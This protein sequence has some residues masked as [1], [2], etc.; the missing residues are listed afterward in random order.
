[1]H[2]WFLEI[3]SSMNIGVYVCV[4]PQEGLITS[5]VKVTCNN[6]ISKFYG[7]SV[8]LCDTAVDR[9]NG[10]GLRNTVHCKCMPKK[11]KVMRY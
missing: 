4:C 9:L 1:M 6:W 11:T 8:S 7:F 3:V 10:C 2:I 5:Y